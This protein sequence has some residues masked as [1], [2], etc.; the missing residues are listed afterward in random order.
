MP[1]QGQHSFLIDR[2][3]NVVPVPPEEAQAKIQAGWV[4]ASREQVDDF[5]K[6]E[7]FGSTGQAAAAFG[8]HAARA[9]TFGASTAAET[10]LGV[11]PEDIE[12]REKYNP[13]A[14]TLGT[15]AGIAAPLVLSGGASAVTA[16]ALT[17]ELGGG[18][19]RLLGASLPQATSVAGRLALKAA[20]A[21]LGSAVEGA[22]YGAGQLV[23]EKALGDPNMTAQ[24]AMATIGIGGLLGGAI[25]AGGGALGSLVGEV[26]TSALGKKLSGWLG[27]VEAKANLKAAGG[28]KSDIAYLASRKGGV[29][30]L[31]KIA[32]EMREQGL[33]DGVATTPGEVLARSQSLISSADSDASNILALADSSPNAP[34]FDWEN[35]RGDVGKK[36]LS[37]LRREGSGIDVANRV[38]KVLDDISTAKADGAPLGLSDLRALRQDLD[39]SIG[40]HGKSLD[41]FSKPV[42]APLK[43]F[44]DHLNDLIDQGVETTGGDADAWAAANRKMEI[45]L[46]A[47]KLAETGVK[48]SEGGSMVPFSGLLG[49]AA[50]GA[51]SGPVGAAL[52]LV[53]GTVAKKYGANLVG[54]AARLARNMID[55][56]GATSIIN[57][58]AEGISAE[59]QAGMDV[60]APQAVSNHETVAALSHLERA[61]QESANKLSSM[62]STLARGGI[63]AG[64]VGRHEVEA[65][66][67]GAFA[68]GRDSGERE[69]ARIADQLNHLS[70]PSQMQQAL[71]GFTRDLQEHAPETSMALQITGAKA[72]SFL[73]AR[74]PQIPR[75]G[76]LA[77]QLTPSR[78]EIAKFHRYYQALQHPQDLLKQAA[79]GTLTPEAVEAIAAVMPEYYQAAKAAVMEK[80]VAHPGKMPYQ[81][82]MMVSMLL[83]QDMDGTTSGPMIAANQQAFTYNYQPPGAHHAK[84]GGMPKAGKI[85]LHSRLLTPMQASSRRR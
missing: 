53:G 1:D 40:Y 35:I 43:R 84:G 18:A 61:S 54:T 48:N 47:K 52:G 68:R 7:K 59:R 41:P 11:A 4:P 51:H 3:G 9:L 5:K 73:K 34:R 63:K 24:H 22:V 76:P 55:E 15:V 82:R 78:A 46:T 21:G 27:D 39:K 56:G 85:T 75:A 14:S 64:N 65:G 80:L 72:I 33:L 81:N 12:A 69:Y 19:A 25:G 74:L 17:A 58:T 38:E 42:A 6:A 57:R 62:A 60:L 2:I 20:T 37:D 45:G 71:E 79:S 77:P 66:L 23:H 49:G 32:R 8:E 50:A 28:T 16:P 36:V 44:R 26:N 13:T 67:S 31:N 30:N 10:A 29:G 70:D 83:G